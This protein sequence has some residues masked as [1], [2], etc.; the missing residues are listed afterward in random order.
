[1]SFARALRERLA[2]WARATPDAIAIEGSD[3]APLAYAALEAAIGAATEDLARRGVSPGD[4]VLLLEPTSA[5]RVITLFAAWARGASIALLDPDVGP[6]R[7]AAQRARASI[8]ASRVWC[9]EA[10][11]LE[12]VDGAAL[13]VD[14]AIEA[15]AVAYVV[16]TSGSTGA[17]KAVALPDAGLGVLAAAQAALFALG[18]GAR[19]WPLLSPGFDAS[20]SDLVAPLWA[21]ATLV[22]DRSAAA[23]DVGAL[24]EVLARRRITHVDLPP[25]WLPL[26]APEAWPACTSTLVVGGEPMAPAVREAHA[27]ARRL[28]NVYGPTEVTVCTHGEVVA[29]GRGAPTLGRA[30]PGVRERVVDDDGRDSA[31]GEL[32]LASPGVFLAYLGDPEATRRARVEC[33]GHVFYRTGDQVAR[34][35]DGALVFVGRADRQIKRAGVRIELDAVEAALVEI[36]GCPS[37]VGLRDDALVGCVEA[38]MIDVPALRAALAARL[39]SVAVPRVWVA[40]P[41]LPRLASGKLDRRAALQS[42][43][44]PA[45]ALAAPL[46]GG[47]SSA[48]LRAQVAARVLGLVLDPTLSFVAQGG[49]SFAA[50]AI[51]AQLAALGV[52]H[53]RARLG[54]DAPLAA[55]LDDAGAAEAEAWWAIAPGVI[56]PSVADTP[57]GER[58]RAVRRRVLVTGATGFLGRAILS[59]LASRGDVDVVAHVRAASDAEARARLGAEAARGID[60]VLLG[61]LEALS[62]AGVDVILHAAGRV[63]LGGGAAVAAA[64][65]AAHVAPTAALASAARATGSRLVVAGSLAPFVLAE[66]PAAAVDEAMDVAVLGR[67]A[68]AY[69]AAKAEAERHARAHGAVVA[70][71][72]LLVGDR[73]T[74]RAHPRCQLTRL[75]AATRALGLWPRLGGSP[76]L[77]VTPVDV[78]AAALVRAGLDVDAPPAVLHVATTTGVVWDELRRAAPCAPA[79]ASVDAVWTRLVAAPRPGLAVLAAGLRHRGLGDPTPAARAHDPFLLTETTIDRR[80]TEAALGADLSPTVDMTHLAKLWRFAETLDS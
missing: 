9:A 56:A 47:V 65:F 4:R 62:T 15:R 72:G 53:A 28:V 64:L 40:V 75:L 41:R 69:A 49:D 18:P 10:G 30:L 25:S 19:A 35:T 29:P 36:S 68:G 70:R 79:E 60:A 11:E 14:A 66:S 1:M 63:E 54:D 2:R 17:P 55:W 5:A 6:A 24:L 23:L 59:V 31:R 73:V 80:R 52:S 50:L 33:D 21:G 16:T 51:D 22:I 3:G 78:A 61:P 71:L 45:A 32:W 27:R 57:R 39:P 48:A 13:D 7:S 26:V 77:D 76:R 37:I 12:P 44:T 67:V 42:V 34:D 20:L 8:G 38:P 74:G 58:A 46:T 43:T